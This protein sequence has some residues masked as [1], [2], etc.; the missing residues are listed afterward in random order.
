MAMSRTLRRSARRAL[1]TRGCSHV[2]ELRLV[3]ANRHHV[4]TAVSGFLRE[5][6]AFRLVVLLLRDGVEPSEWTQLLPRIPGDKELTDLL[7]SWLVNELNPMA[8][9][10]V[11][12]AAL[13]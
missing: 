7:Q 8:G 11:G 10:Y 1:S 12:A 3:N 5:G 4:A 2:A 6:E 13:L 9:V